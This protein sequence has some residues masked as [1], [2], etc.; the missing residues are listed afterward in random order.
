MKPSYP[1]NT[2]IITP[3]PGSGSSNRIARPFQPEHPLVY[4]GQV[5]HA[6]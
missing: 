3:I 2:A 4:G 1:P 6:A 5:R